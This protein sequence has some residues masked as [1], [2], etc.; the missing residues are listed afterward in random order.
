M[1]LPRVYE[2]AA[3]L[4][5]AQRSYFRNFTASLRDNPLKRKHFIEIEAELATLDAAA[6]NH[7]KANAGPLFMKHETPRD[8]RGAASVLNEARAYNFL[9]RRGY[10]SVAFIPRHAKGKTPDLRAKAGSVDVLCEAKTIN[11][12]ERAGEDRLIPAFFIKLASTIARA[13][14]QLTGYSAVPEIRKILYLLIDFD[15][16]PSARIEDFLA[17]T[18]ER[19]AEFLPSNLEIVLDTKMRKLILQSARDNRQSHALA[20]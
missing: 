1:E 12:V 10:T 11:R 14:R 15:H 2:L 9:V 18:E 16:V 6:W 17:Q 3:S 8:W 19:K 7:L 4:K 5:G 13:D 20:T